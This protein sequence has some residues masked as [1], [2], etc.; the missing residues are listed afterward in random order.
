VPL[1]RSLSV[2]FPFS[3]AALAVLRVRAPNPQASQS[4]AVSSSSPTPLILQE[5]DGE[6]RLRRPG[7]PTG[8]S[9]VAEFIIKIDKQN[10]NAQD[11]YVGYEILYPGAMI[12]VHKHHNSEEV[13][14]V[15]EG[16]ITH[17]HGGRR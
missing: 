2:F 4:A 3:T 17:T 11:F 13:V 12:P 1:R 14:I 5:N 8:S 9:S 6:H 10:G 16:G 15:E 7:G